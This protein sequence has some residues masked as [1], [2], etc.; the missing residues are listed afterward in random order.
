MVGQRVEVPQPADDQLTHDPLVRVDP[1]SNVRHERREVERRALDHEIVQQAVQH[2]R[3]A[4]DVEVGVGLELRHGAP[5]AIEGRHGGA[6]DRLADVEERFAA[7]VAQARLVRL[8][9]AGEDGLDHGGGVRRHRRLRG[10][11]GRR[12]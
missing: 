4:A 1:I 9:E 8:D 12:G 5:D 10:G 6:A 2:V 3:P 11:E 7:V